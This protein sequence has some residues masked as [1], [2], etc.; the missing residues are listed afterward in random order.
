MPYTYLVV[1]APYPFENERGLSEIIVLK[2]Q[3]T[4]QVPKTGHKSFLGGL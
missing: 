1:E 3:L 4:T 2:G